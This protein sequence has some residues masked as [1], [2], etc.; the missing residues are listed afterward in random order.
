MKKSREKKRAAK[1]E[2]RN[3]EETIAATKR[4]SSGAAEATADIRKGKPPA[5]VKRA[6]DAKW[7]K[8]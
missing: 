6:N 1:V 2:L 5:E 8:P 7:I 3:A 4:A